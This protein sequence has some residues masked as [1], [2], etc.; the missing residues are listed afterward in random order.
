MPNVELLQRTMQYINDHPEQHN[1]ERWVNICG[2]SACFAGW[3]AIFSG[4]SVEEIWDVNDMYQVGAKLLDIRYLDA[5][6][7]FAPTNTR[8]ML[9]LMVKDLVNGERLQY[10]RLYE[11]EAS[12][13]S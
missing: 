4:M 2:T 8:A 9:E 6:V 3:A 1:Q 12:G 10:S 7:L 5:N 11:R 13:P